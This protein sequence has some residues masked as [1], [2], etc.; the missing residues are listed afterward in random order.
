MVKGEDE[1][2]GDDEVVEMKKVKKKVVKKKKVKGKNGKVEY[3][4]EVVEVEV[5]VPVVVKKKKK[6]F[7]DEDDYSRNADKTIDPL[8][9][10]GP[11]RKR[12]KMRGGPSGNFDEDDI[13]DAFETIDKNRKNRGGIKNAKGQIEESDEAEEIVVTIGGSRMRRPKKK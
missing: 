12:Q 6:G 8:E 13:E 7:G 4:D 2:E 5:E 3:V 10:E 11:G 9:Y 1:G